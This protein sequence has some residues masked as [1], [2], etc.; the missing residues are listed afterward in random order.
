MPFPFSLSPHSSKCEPRL[1]KSLATITCNNS[2]TVHKHAF[3]WRRD[4][5]LSTDS[6]TGSVIQSKFKSKKKKTLSGL[7]PLKVSSPKSASQTLT[8]PAFCIFK[9]RPAHSPIINNRTFYCP[10]TEPYISLV[11]NILPSV[12]IL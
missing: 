8:L 11:Q 5:Q 7:F 9:Y 4:P 2:I 3:F 10:T 1:Q 12:S 6:Q